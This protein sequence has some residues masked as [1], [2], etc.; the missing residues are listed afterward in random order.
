MKKILLITVISILC[1][2]PNF[3]QSNY[4]VTIDQN[5][6]SNLENSI[7]YENKL[8]YN[9][10][11]FSAYFDENFTTYKDDTILHYIIFNTDI[12]IDLSTDKTGN[13]FNL[14][15]RAY[16]EKEYLEELFSITIEEGMLNEVNITSTPIEFK[17]QD[18]IDY[19]RTFLNKNKKQDIFK[20]ELYKIKYLEIYLGEDYSSNFSDIHNFKALETL[21]IARKD[22]TSKTINLGIQELEAPHLKNLI[23]RNM[24]INKFSSIP[25]KQNIETLEIIASEV[26]PDMIESFHN[27]KS[28]TLSNCYLKNFNPCPRTLENYSVK[29]CVYLGKESYKEQTV[30]LRTSNLK[31]LSLLNLNIS[32]YDS[33]LKLQSSMDVDT[34]EVNISGMMLE[35]KDDMKKLKKLSIEKANLINLQYLPNVENLSEVTL[36]HCKLSQTNFLEKAKKLKKLDVSDNYIDEFL[37]IKNNTE[38]EYLNISNNP[39]E[40]LPNFNHFP[41]LNFLS[42]NIENATEFPDL[43]NLK[44]LKELAV[45][46]K[47]S[48]NFDE[49]NLSDSVNFLSFYTYENEKN[50]LSVL[51]Q[52]SLLSF[53]Y[54]GGNLKNEIISKKITKNDAINIIKSESKNIVKNISDSGLSSEKFLEVYSSTIN[55]VI[56]HILDD[57]LKKD[58]FSN[59][60]FEKFMYDVSKVLSNE[61]TEFYKD[62]G[63]EGHT[64]NG[65]IDLSDG[66]GRKNLYWTLLENNGKIYH[67]NTIYDLYYMNKLSVEIKED[68]NFKENTN[69]KTF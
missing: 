41:L 24:T 59:L 69:Y 22:K 60:E 58:S 20:W 17:N 52:S 5:K 15:G 53:K 51:D 34:E 16:V 67:I 63:Y 48:I 4:S 9:L 23:L 46:N 50:I 66:N 19:V 29:N 31:E 55:L 35:L 40:K 10:G 14:N 33:I 36:S 26:T 11:D 18:L 3:A 8:L 32:D 56:T 62:T 7:T 38:L 65:V 42:F 28:L 37:N 61:I 47:T 6:I 68:D 13:L 27:L 45:E 12:P 25:L 39:I 21:S 2:F 54:S 43:S 44:F 1:I 49:I 57:F 64:V 30:F